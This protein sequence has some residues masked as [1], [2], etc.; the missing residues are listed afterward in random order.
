[1]R[2]GL[3]D[4]NLPGRARATFVA[5]VAV[6]VGLVSVSM[7]GAVRG[8]HQAARIERSTAVQDAFDNARVALSDELVLEL[9]YLDHPSP[10]VRARYRAAV[11]RF[12]RQLDR[13]AAVAV[14]A[15]DTSA[16]AGIRREHAV[17]AGVVER[18]FDAVDRQGPQALAGDDVAAFGPLQSLS[19]RLERAGDRE[20]AQVHRQLADHRRGDSVVMV[21][22]GIL[23]AAGL[24]LV[25]LGAVVMTGFR[26]SNE[27]TRQEAE[28]ALRRSTVR[29]RSLVENSADLTAVYGTD[30][31]MSYCSPASTRL[32]GFQ[33]D[34]FVA[35]AA[36][37]L[38]HPDDLDALH[39]AAARATEAPGGVVETVEF[40]IRHRD[41]SWRM[42]A[43]SLNDRLAD[44]DIAGFVVNAH[45]ITDR[46]AAE[47]D[48]A[49]SATHDSLT[50]L[51]N[52]ALLVDRLEVALARAS[53]GRTELALLFCDLDRFKVVNDSMGH[54]A[55]DRVLVAVAH[56]LSAA[57][58]PG[59]T[60]ARLGGDEFVVCCEGID[61]PAEAEAVAQRLSRALAAP[62]D[63]DGRELY[64]RAS[65]GIRTA[66]P[67]GA[68]ETPGDLLRD[69]DSA[70]YQ[71][72]AA[73]R[74][75]FALY[76]DALRDK[77][78]T[79]LELE[80]SLHRALERD[81]FRVHYQPTVSVHDGAI[82]GVEALVR[83][84]RPGRG[85]VPPADFI[86]V[87]EETGLIVP[88][89]AWVLD[90]ACCQLRRWQDAGAVGLSM[91]VNLSARQLR[92]S[93]LVAEVAAILDRTGIPAGDL[94]LEVT[95]SVLMDD[96]GVAESVLAALKGLGVRL[97]IDDFGTGYSSLAYLRRFPVDVLKV[98][99]SFVAGLGS[100]SEASAIVTTVV[101]LAQALQL[102]TIAEGVE[103]DEQRVQLEDL[104]CQLAQGF[105][106]SRPVAPGELDDRLLGLEVRR[107]TA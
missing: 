107:L 1:M 28:A 72:K 80:S 49:H 22:S 79:R 29:F 74:A 15:D 14:D 91:S 77:T 102:E 11:A 10:A 2:R 6:L 24:A 92:D 63:V 60:V 27:R 9:T 73:G 25:A 13:V 85:L 97:A 61:G 62:I 90:Q 96:A 88:I 16:L 38:V 32:L 89:G 69:A 42:F 31:S 20:T 43:A 101:D 37:E 100:Q 52:R 105:L 99:R 57:V 59:D 26:R 93:G 18:T 53:R 104:G 94:C 58:R 84:E 54:A 71:A 8:R 5:L 30:G 51:P 17:N 87:A 50:G 47:A 76:D 83:W 98:D 34:E 81:E 4:P 46:K 70:M 67:G 75:G 48:L 56:R 64:V 35:M 68:R 106:W 40:R 23:V 44:T 65:I 7:W 45:D 36:E 78:A 21:L 3:D 41:G 12:D 39:L 86:G 33:P 66:R 103:T 82:V 19:R 55:G 95:E